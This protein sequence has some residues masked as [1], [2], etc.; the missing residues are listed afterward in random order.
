MGLDHLDFSKGI[1]Q[2]IGYKEFAEYYHQ[3][4]ENI[5]SDESLQEAKERLCIRTLQYAQT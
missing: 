2:A 3:C 4:M 5:A 1:L